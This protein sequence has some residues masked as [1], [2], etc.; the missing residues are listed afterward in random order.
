MTDNTNENKTKNKNWYFRLCDSIN[1]VVLCDK[2]YPFNFFTVFFFVAAAIV[3][4]GISGNDYFKNVA[5]LVVL[6]TIYL[7]IFIAFISC[8]IY[9]YRKKLG[10]WVTVAILLFHYFTLI[11]IGIGNS[12]QF[13]LLY[14]GLAF[15]YFIS[16]ASWKSA[17]DLNKKGGLIDTIL[18]AIGLG[19][20]VIGGI[21][22][23]QNHVYGKPLIIAGVGLVYIYAI[24]RVL[25]WLICTQEK[26]K[27]NLLKTMFYVVIYLALIVWLPFF[28]CWAGVEKSVVETI[29]V[30]IYAAI[31]GGALALAGVAWTINYS[32]SQNRKAELDKARPLFTF[33]F[34]TDINPSVNN[35]K[36]CYVDDHDINA[37]KEFQSLPVGA[38]SYM[39]LEN[40]ER[41]SFTIKRFFYD[42]EWH[43]TYAN[44]NVLPNN[45]I[46]ILLF[47]R[48]LKTHPVMEI[49][50][51]FNRKFY[52]DL[53]F[54]SL[55]LR[56]DKIYTT[57]SELKEISAEEVL[58]RGIVI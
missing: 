2:G 58:A 18:L 57:L 26:L 24:A 27:M 42:S 53:M 55:G 51:V 56:Q 34:F 48:D 46:L 32:I 17:K 12:R 33:T 21:L 29:I 45:E 39:K 5:F 50:D 13:S 8:T 54:V 28:L 52:Y 15:V 31:L 4:P 10:H 14:L 44:N 30:P 25:F 36:I 7:I 41:S 1:K 37:Q 6:E 38:E 9:F 19:C 11:E 40:S 49:E 16:Y 22:Y 3:M 43:N 35:R 20:F 23:Q 47:R